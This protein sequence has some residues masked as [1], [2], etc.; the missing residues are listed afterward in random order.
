LGS[1]RKSD[2][3]VRATFRQPLP[4]RLSTLLIEAP[5]TLETEVRLTVRAP[6]RFDKD[7]AAAQLLTE[8]ARQRWLKGSP[9]PPDA[10]EVRYDA[11]KLAGVITMRASAPP[12]EA[13]AAL[14][15]ARATL[16]ALSATVPPTAAEIERSRLEVLNAFTIRTD[17][18]SEPALALLDAQ[19]YGANSNDAT[20]LLRAVTPADVRQLAAKLFDASS[21]ATIA[22]GDSAKL[23]AELTRVGFSVE[24]PEEMATAQAAPANPRPRSKEVQVSP[25]VPAAPPA[26]AKRP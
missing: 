10:L 21:L 9:A 18:T 13:A 11:Y 15:A 17:A 19:T 2:Q 3:Q 16:Q 24:T 20:A 6:A 25:L 1:W 12:A 22:A 14:A 23:K 7:Y 4:P 8:I 5:N 26:P